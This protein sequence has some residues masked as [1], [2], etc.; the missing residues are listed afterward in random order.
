MLRDRTAGPECAV[1]LSPVAAAEKS[2]RVEQRQR[3]RENRGFRKH[4]HTTAAVER[5]RRRKAVIT[6]LRIALV[7]V[8]CLLGL[9]SNAHAGFMD[10][11]D[12]LSGPGPFLGVGGDIRLACTS[13]PNE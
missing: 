4:L 7:L 5:R 2:H 12:E 13:T 8:V 3:T 10:Y 9:S 1:V 6:R 11:L